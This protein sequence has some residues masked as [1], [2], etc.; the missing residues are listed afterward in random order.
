MLTEK[1]VRRR[2]PQAVRSAANGLPTF[3]RKGKKTFVLA[4]VNNA[5]LQAALGVIVST[6]DG[7]PDHITPKF[8][9]KIERLRAEGLVE[10]K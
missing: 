2:F 3:F 5:A 10:L 6:E 7:E 8:A 1:E 9:A 4:Q